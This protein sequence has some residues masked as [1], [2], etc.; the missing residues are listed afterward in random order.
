MSDQGTNF[1]ATSSPDGGLPQGLDSWIGEGKK[2]KTPDEA[3]QSV[4][5]AQEHI[6]KLEQTL[7]ELRDE[8]SSRSKL[9]DLIQRLDG[10]QN[11][12]GGGEPSTPAQ[13]AESFDPQKINTLLEEMLSKR[14]KETQTKTNL[15]KVVSALQEQFGDQAEAAY[16]NKAKELGLSKQEFDQIAA[17]SPQMVLSHF[18]KQEVRGNVATRSDV[19]TNA[20]PQGGGKVKEGT[21]AW[22]KELRRTDPKTYFSREVQLRMHE[23]AQ[24]LGKDFYE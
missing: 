11:K 24:R 2:Y 4:P 17:R 7:N 1:E 16:I 19:N 10:Q 8:L 22:Y 14:E 15:G 9:D 18:P 3:L 23:D 12:D 6:R 20:L 21:H 13:P 5:H